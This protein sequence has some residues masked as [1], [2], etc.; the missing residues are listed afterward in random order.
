MRDS[1]QLFISLSGHPV[2]SLLSYIC[3]HNRGYTLIWMRSMRCGGMIRMTC[4]EVQLAAV[5]LLHRLTAQ[6]IS[7]VRDNGR[8]F[9]LY[10]AGTG[11]DHREPESWTV[12]DWI[13]YLEFLYV[14]LPLGLVNTLAHSLINKKKKIF[15]IY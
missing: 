10:I 12:T 4:R 3:F 5:S 8:P 11:R 7:L 2:C 6:I 9:A 13:R 1:L 15:L 14:D